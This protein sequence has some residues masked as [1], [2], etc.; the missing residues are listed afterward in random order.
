MMQTA[1]DLMQGHRE[2]CFVAK[3]QSPSDTIS[4]N[5]N[6]C[7]TGKL[8]VLRF[9]RAEAPRASGRSHPKTARVLFADKLR[10]L[11]T[12]GANNWPFMTMMQT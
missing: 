5:D 7:K 10:T 11:E 6:V 8:E 12:A 4:H 2:S 1:R 3:L 9:L